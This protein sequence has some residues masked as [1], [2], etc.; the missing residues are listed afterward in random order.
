MCVAF[1]WL[2]VHCMCV[3]DR[4]KYIYDIDY[5]YKLRRE[6]HSMHMQFKLMHK[7]NGKK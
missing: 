3:R 2:L 6:L 7:I 1:P 4:E 5:V